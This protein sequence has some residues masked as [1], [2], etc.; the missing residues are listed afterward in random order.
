[1]PLQKKNPYNERNQFT[2]LS[3]KKKQHE[4]GLIL[5]HKAPI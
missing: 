3:I 2:L 5:K 4:S 1:M